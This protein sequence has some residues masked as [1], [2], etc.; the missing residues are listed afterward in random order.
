MDTVAERAPLTR[1]SAIPVSWL[2]LLRLSV[3]AML[4][5]IDI[6]FVLGIPHFY[7][8][9]TTPCELPNCHPLVLATTDFAM[10]ESAGLSA[11]FYAVAQISIEVAN[12][13][14]VNVLSIYYLRRLMTHWLAYVANFAILQFILMANVAFSLFTVYPAYSFILDFMFDVTAGSLFTLIYIMPSGRFVPRWSFL[15]LLLGLSEIFTTPLAAYYPE[16]YDGA[17]AGLFASR[18]GI[19]FIAGVV[20][21]VYRFFRVSD[22]TQRLQTRWVILGFS[23][24]IVGLYGWGYFMEYLVYQPGAPRVWIHLLVMP[25]LMFVTVVP[26]SIALTISIIEHRLW[27]I[28]LIISRALVYAMLMGTFTATYVFLA[29]VLSILFGSSS[30]VIA[31]LLVTLVVVLTFQALRDRIQR[32]VN[33]LLFGQR[34]DPQ[35]VLLELSKQLQT[36]LMPRDLL[37]A[38]VETIARTL[39]LPY[40]AIRIRGGHAPLMETVFGADH[41]PVQ[42]FALVYQNESVGELVVGQRAPNEPLNR[43]DQVVLQGIAQQLGA[44]VYAVRLQGDLQSARER[45]VIAREEERRRLRRDLH[46]G[47]GPSLASLPL[48]IDAAIDLN[49]R[50]PDASLN[51]LGDV[52]RQAQMMVADVRRVVHDLRPHALDELGL[53]EALRGALGQLRTHPDGVQIT[54]DVDS[55]PRHLTAAVEVAAYRITMEAITNVIRHAHAQHCRIGLSVNEPLRQLQLTIEDDGV[56]M[57]SAVVPNVGLQSMRERAEELGG[58]FHVQAAPG[59]GSLISVTLPLSEAGESS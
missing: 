41:T 43:A 4:I 31:S 8:H 59:G 58:T 50:D 54:L 48:K 10:L 33:R 5:A 11:G 49:A 26:F 25:I 24:M 38:S 15:F 23:L 56:G 37:N 17:E 47:L 39:R 22:A 52:K 44:V 3:I 21:Q 27:N 42:A 12:V 53:V 20:F 35:A 13:L 18:F 7:T 46:D 55:L 34:D 51:L 6:S 2:P 29:A 9:L 19:S 16:D 14:F 30:G 57:P 40:A 45:L 36:A 28:N 1:I 32:G